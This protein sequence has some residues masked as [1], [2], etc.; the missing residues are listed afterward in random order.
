M[1][2][3]A[4]VGAYPLGHLRLDDSTSRAA[5]AK[6]RGMMLFYGEDP[7]EIRIAGPESEFIELSAILLQNYAVL[8]RQRSGTEVARYSRFPAFDNCKDFPR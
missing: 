2:S 1:D 6:E 7:A 5:N 8:S 3:L 4:I